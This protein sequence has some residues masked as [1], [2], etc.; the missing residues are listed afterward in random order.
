MKKDF[1]KKVTD[2]IDI[3]PAPVITTNIDGNSKI[4]SK[5]GAFFTIVV[6]AILSAFAVV[7]LQTMIHYSKTSFT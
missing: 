5:T 2:T 7:H 4:S 1:T 6:V 3:F